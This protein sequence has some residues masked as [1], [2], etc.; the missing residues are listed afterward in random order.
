MLGNLVT[1]K[2]EARSC[3]M[4]LKHRRPLLNQLLRARGLG[5]L[6]HPPADV[7]SQPTGEAGE[8]KANARGDGA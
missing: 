2:L 4:L 3:N 8:A 6:L 5:A 1:H 7:C